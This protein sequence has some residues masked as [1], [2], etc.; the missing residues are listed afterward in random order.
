MITRW[1]LVLF[2]TAPLFGAVAPIV[3]PGHYSGQDVELHV[4]VDED[5]S[6]KFTIK[7]SGSESATVV[8]EWGDPQTSYFNLGPDRRFMLFF[9]DTADGIILLQEMPKVDEA[10]NI[11]EKARNYGLKDDALFKQWQKDNAAQRDD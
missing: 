9:G 7:T 11:I 3:P 2:F 8:P 1:L 6:F 4:T 10:G 5:G